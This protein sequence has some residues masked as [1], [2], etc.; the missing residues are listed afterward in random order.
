MEWLLVCT[1]FLDTYVSVVILGISLV[2]LPA[3]RMM[4]VDF[5]AYYTKF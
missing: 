2:C 3:A 1:F 4:D 5:I